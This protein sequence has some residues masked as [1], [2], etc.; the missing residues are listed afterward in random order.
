MKNFIID[1]Y[2]YT[3]EQ[4]IHSFE[5]SFTEAEFKSID[6]LNVNDKMTRISGLNNTEVDIMRM[7]DTVVKQTPKVDLTFQDFTTQEAA[8]LGID[9]GEYAF[10]FQIY[11]QSEEDF[12]Y[13]ATN[14]TLDGK[15][16]Q[17]ALNSEVG[18]KVSAE[19][20]S[21]IKQFAALKTK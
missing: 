13:A 2:A 5:E 8:D 4:M 6:E 12:D 18:S 21:I 17:I 14:G 10:E 19:V 1:G 3:Q 15:N 7:P 9:V 11:D 20:E 16:L